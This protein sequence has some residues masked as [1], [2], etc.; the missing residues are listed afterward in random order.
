MSAFRSAPVRPWVEGAPP[1]LCAAVAVERAMQVQ[2]VIC[3]VLAGTLI[4]LQ[5]A[6]ILG[7]HMR[8]QPAPL[9]RPL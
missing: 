1:I 6:D 2:E 9:A 3:R 4:W 5:G 8:A 7:S